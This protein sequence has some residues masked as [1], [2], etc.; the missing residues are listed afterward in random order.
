MGTPSPEALWRTKQRKT[1]AERRHAGSQPDLFA[2]ATVHRQHRARHPPK[3]T[4]LTR[5]SDDPHAWCRSVR[6]KL[7]PETQAALLASAANWL[8]VGQRVQIVTTA[9]TID[10]TDEKRFGRVGVIWRIA[11]SV[12][13]EWTYVN[14]DLIGAERTEK[15]E[16]LEIRDL[17]PIE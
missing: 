9:R 15:V 17:E 14:L 3:P 2:G 11:S 7:D 1:A 12:F 5:N 13:P 16:F 10:G 4:I 6:A 8:R